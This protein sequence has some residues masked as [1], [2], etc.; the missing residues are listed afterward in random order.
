MMSA[1]APLATSFASTLAWVIVKVGQLSPIAPW[2]L[3]FLIEGFPS[4][5]VSVIAWSVIPDSPQT[6]H[7]LTRRERR[8]LGFASAMKSPLLL[9]QK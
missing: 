9:R 7:Y 2:R 6:A 3:L 1:A 4:V 8:L 5:I